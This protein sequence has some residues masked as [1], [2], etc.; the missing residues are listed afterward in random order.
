MTREERAQEAL[1]QAKAQMGAKQS[2]KPNGAA[3]PLDLV[4]AD[5]IQL[6]IHKPGL[7][8]GLLSTTAMTV[9]YGESGTGKTFVVLDLACRIAAGMHWRDHETTQGV[10]CYVAAEAPKSVEHRVWAWMHHHEIEHLSLVVV[11]ST[12]NLLDGDTDTLIT[13]LAQVAAERGRIGLVVVDTL[14]RAMVG[15]ENAPEDMG[16][17]IATCA[18]IREAATASVLIVHHTGKDQARGARGHSCL[19]AATDVELEVTQGCIKVSKNR[20][21]QEGQ[22]YGFTLKQVELGLN[23]KGRMVTT[24]VAVEAAPPAGAGKKRK[25]GPNE[26]LVFDA[27]VCAV[28]DHADPPPPSPQVPSHAKGATVARWRDAAMLVLP[29][30]EAK[31][32][33]EA[34]NRALLSLVASN[35]VRHLDGFAWLP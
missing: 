27:L 17:F 30:G 26:R 10:V 28:A 11:R 32:K 2:T 13:M 22:I 14:A 34:F 35:E 7:I 21:G 8:D 23:T 1:R 20:D 15:N 16:A 4:W 25:L 6:D 9:A 33:V 29:Q 18:R 19:H 3:P 24:C 5:D 12:V 31:R